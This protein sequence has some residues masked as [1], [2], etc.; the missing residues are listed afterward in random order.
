M[1]KDNAPLIVAIFL[2]MGGLL[3]G[4]LIS[5]NSTGIVRAASA[6][7]ETTFF[8]STAR[9]AENVTTLLG[10]RIPSPVTAVSDNSGSNTKSIFSNTLGAV[11]DA[12]AFGSAQN[13]SR[14]R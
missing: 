14:N 13:S 8:I 11:K 7:Q 10:A 4:I 9:G 3:S 1:K 6:H 12:G 5:E 2:V